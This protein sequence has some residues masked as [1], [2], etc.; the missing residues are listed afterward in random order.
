[1]R[2]TALLVQ[3]VALTMAMTVS[4]YSADSPKTMNVQGR[5]TGSDG[6]PYPAGDW[7]FNFKIYDAELPGTG[8][9]VWP[10]RDGEDQLIATAF[11]RNTMTNN[12]GGTSDEEFRNVA[13]VDRVNTTMAVWMGTTMACAQCHN[14][15]YDPLSQE[16]Y[17]QLFAFFNNSADADQRDESPL[18][19]IWTPEQTQQNLIERTAFAAFIADQI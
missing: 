6:S 12:E 1:M 14:H 9:I 11:H 5:L 19:E 15:K 4:V 13:I 3:V 7:T 8:E 16:E 10:D 18:L 2:R 17:F